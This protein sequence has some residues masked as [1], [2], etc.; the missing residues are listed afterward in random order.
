MKVSF[1]D[2][3][4]H[5]PISSLNPSNKYIRFSPY[6]LYKED[7]THP[8]PEEPD[9][10]VHM[11]SYIQNITSQSV[12]CALKD[13]EKYN[14]RVIAE[15]SMTCC[16]CSKIYSANK[17]SANLMMV[18]IVVLIMIVVFLTMKLVKD[19]KLF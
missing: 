11:E 17:T 12:E 8:E 16:V 15:H 2:D 9:I 4:E 6:P 18:L 3:K 14:C 5:T 7:F 19:K 10:P 13:P 1:E